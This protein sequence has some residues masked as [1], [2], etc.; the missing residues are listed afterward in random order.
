MFLKLL[1]SV[2]IGV[3]RGSGKCSSKNKMNKPFKNS[4]TRRHPRQCVKV[5]RSPLLGVEVLGSSWLVRIQKA[6]TYCQI[7]E[8]QFSLPPY[9]EERLHAKA[10]Q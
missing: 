6:Y 8:G 3:R 2:Q 7:S 4:D 10:D 9:T 5:F 1:V